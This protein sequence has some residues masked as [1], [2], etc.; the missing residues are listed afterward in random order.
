MPAHPRT[1]L[2]TKCHLLEQSKMN[3]RKV[4]VVVSWRIFDSGDNKLTTPCENILTM[5][6]HQM[7]KKKK[8][9]DSCCI[10][11]PKLKL[12][13]AVKIPVHKYGELC[14]NRS[15]SNSIEVS[16]SSIIHE[17]VNSSFVILKRFLET[18]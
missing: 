14:S 1:H 10:Q 12:K 16:I 18:K 2:Y 6:I 17:F 5:Q 13:N 8:K 3:R 7:L 11:N 9:R 15:Y 4:D